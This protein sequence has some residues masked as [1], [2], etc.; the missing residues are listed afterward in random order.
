M[1][2]RNFTTQQRIRK[3]TKRPTERIP[4]YICNGFS[5]ITECHH[6]FPVNKAAIEIDNT[7]KTLIHVVWLCPNCHSY[8]HKLEHLKTKSKRIALFREMGKAISDGILTLL[9]E[10]NQARSRYTG[11][12]IPEDI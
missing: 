4:C 10:S 8:W 2:S 7:G 6:L 11:I 5:L 1:A 12:D 9:D 3:T